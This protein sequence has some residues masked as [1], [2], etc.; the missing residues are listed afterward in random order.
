MEEIWRDIPEYEGYY[1]M[2]NLLRVRSLYF[3]NYGNFHKYKTPKIRKVCVSTL[4]PMIILGFD[5][6]GNKKT[7]YMHHLVAKLFIPNP[8]GY[9]VVMHKDD[10]KMNYAIN[11]LEWGTDRKNNHDAFYRGR[12]PRT[13]G[14]KTSMA[15]ITEKDAL[16]IFRSEGK[17]YELREKYNVTY[18]VIYNIKN[19]N[20]WNHV[21]GLPRNRKTTLNL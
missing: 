7:L 20:T 17:G 2:S 10:N 6:L 11:N 3:Y 16:E 14:S 4:Y 18:T 13:L 21:T 1:Q 5:V 9:P 8:N 19:G 15:K 12:I